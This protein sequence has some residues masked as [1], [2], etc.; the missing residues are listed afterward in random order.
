[1]VFRK[2]GALLTNEKWTYNSQSIEVV[3]DFNYLGTVFNYTGSFC[4]NIEYVTG[5]ALKV[6]NVLFCK[7]NNFDLSPKT[8]CQQFDAF[9][10][11]ILNFSCEVWGYAKSKDL[12]R[13]HL[14]FCK[15]LSRV[16]SNTCSAAVYGELGRYPLYNHRYIRIIF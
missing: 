9:V 1:M 5:K 7:C 3:G 15:R 11:P 4:K 14:N 8:V 10:T 6:L 13:I 2:R 16:R 12:D